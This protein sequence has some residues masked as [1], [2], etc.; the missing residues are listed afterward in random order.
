M[1]NDGTSAVSIESVMSRDSASVAQLFP[2]PGDVVGQLLAQLRVDRGRL[3]LLQPLAPDLA[4][5]RSRIPLAQPLPAL[6]VLRRRQQRPVEAI[7]EPLERVR[8]AKEV[9]ARAHFLMR[10]KCERCLVHLER[11]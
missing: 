6:E 1:A 8:R 4:G 11:G 5:P 9:S 7:A 3:V 2:A 10:P